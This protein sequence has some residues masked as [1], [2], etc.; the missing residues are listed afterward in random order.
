MTEEQEDILR[1]IG[2]YL[3]K[4][5]GKSFVESLI[6]LTIIQKLNYERSDS[7]VLARI[8][9]EMP[10]SLGERLKELRKE[11]KLTLAELACNTHLSTSFLSEVERGLTNPSYYTLQTLAKYYCIDIGS[12]LKGVK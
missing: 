9:F 10:L 4:N 12:L 1:L 11:S 3:D 5:S 6:D 2:K 8:K 7:E